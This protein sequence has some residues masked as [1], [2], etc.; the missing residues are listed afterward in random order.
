MPSIAE[1]LGFKLYLAESHQRKKIID[2]VTSGQPDLLGK[3][4]QHPC[5]YR[6][7][8]AGEFTA[9]R[10][11]YEGFLNADTRTQLSRMKQARKAVFGPSDNND[12]PFSSDDLDRLKF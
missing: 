3:I 10:M 1:Q 2:E 5:G 11:I 6:N 8:M 4:F 9:Q 7:H 12:I